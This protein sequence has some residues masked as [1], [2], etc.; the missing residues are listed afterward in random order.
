MITLCQLCNRSNSN[1]FR[2]G[3]CYIC[4]NRLEKLDSMLVKGTELLKKSDV[5]SFSV[6]TKMPRQWLAAEEAVWDEC[7]LNAESIKSYVNRK[8]IA[9]LAK[10]TGKR[11][12]AEGEVRITFDLD[13][14]VVSAEAQPIWFF[15]RYKKYTE[16]LSQSRWICKKCKGEGCFK[17]DWT[18]KNYFSVEELIGEP[19]LKETGG[20][21]YSMHASGR[22]DVDAINTAGRPFVLRIK[23]PKKRDIELKKIANEIAA[24]GKIDVVD[25]KMVGRETVELVANSHFDKEYEVKIECARQLGADDEKKIRT[26]EGVLISQR[27]PTRV[28]HRRADLIRKRRIFDIAVRER[29]EKTATLLICAEAGTYIKEFVSGDKGRT[30]PSIAEVLGVKTRVVSLKVTAI[31]DEFLRVRGL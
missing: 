13:G 19:F 27:T 1:R 17:C 11:Y 20:T 21:E 28:S 25:L 22:E 30:T 31:H 16:G 3:R 6:S 15:G 18:G 24:A 8:V 2:I 7:F 4:S 9:T 12:S 23:N 10:K 26:L 5:C 29:H 14:G